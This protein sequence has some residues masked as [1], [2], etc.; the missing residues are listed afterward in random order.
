MTAL[1]RRLETTAAFHDLM[2]LVSAGDRL[3][4]EGPRAVGDEVSALEG[5]RWLTEILSVAL[6]CY[7]WADPA[8]PSI[9]P[10][11]GP[12][13]PTRKWGGDNSDAHYHFAPID[14]ARS[15]RLRGRRGDA[16]YLSV[17]VYGG[18]DDGRWSNRIVA[19]LNDR[20]MT[21]APD[22]SFEIVLAPREPAGG[23]S[24]WITLA[25]D[26]VALLTRDYL[27]HPTRERS[28]SWHIE[29]LEP[30]PPPR[31]TDGDLARRFRAAANFLRE[32]TAINPLP[33][34]PALVNA[35]DEP[36]PV[37]AQT[38]GWAAGDA[39]YAMG[40]FDLDDGQALVV[41]GRAPVCAF[42]NVCL[43]NPYMQTYDYRYERVTINGGQMAYEEDGSWRIV[44]AGRD[45][46][47]RNWLSTAG[48][49]SGVVWFRWFLAET[50]PTRPTTT[51]VDVSELVAPRAPAR[52]SS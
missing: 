41:E 2:D 47:V 1:G 52:R 43:W 46:G 29:A 15:Y 40:R 49:Q 27:W 26:S 48:H 28:A 17:T 13:L 24:N 12:G 6:E 21:M 4:L 18:P 50:S 5:Y 23:V 31:L 30:A 20:R 7:L 3:F 44:I 38:Y 25:P 39:S 37:P 8:R 14:P 33:V 34:N 32:L 42:W 16:C 45:P 22:G 9:V 36:Y 10:I 11:A 35:I 51:V 19:T